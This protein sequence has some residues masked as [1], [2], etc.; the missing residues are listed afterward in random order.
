MA[1]PAWHAQSV[2]ITGN[3]WITGRIFTILRMD[4]A[5][6]FR[7]KSARGLLVGPALVLGFS[8]PEI[9]LVLVQ[10]RPEEFEFRFDC[11]IDGTQ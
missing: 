10:I 7:L 2:E 1:G 4:V 11:V 6:G 3:E 8:R 5:Q 9:A